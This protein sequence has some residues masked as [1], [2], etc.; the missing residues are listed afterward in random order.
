LKEFNSFYTKLKNAIDAVDEY[1][2]DLRAA[3]E[4]LHPMPY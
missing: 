1:T 2:K 3:V 4:N